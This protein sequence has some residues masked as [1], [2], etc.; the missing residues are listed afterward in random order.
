VNRSRRAVLAACSAGLTALTGCSALDLEEESPKYDPTRVREIGEKR[1][2]RAP[3]S[4]PLSV[5]DEMVARHRERAQTLID[6]VPNDP[7]VPNGAIARRLS[8]ERGDVV[9]SLAEDE[10]GNDGD[11][12]ERNLPP[13]A[14]DPFERLEH[15]RFT[16]AEAANVDAAYR[17]ATNGITAEPVADRRGRLRS[18]LFAFERDRAYRGDDPAVAVAVHR[19]LERLRNVARRGITPERAFPDDPKT[20]VFQV[21]EI[22]G[23]IEK[24]RGALTDAK[25]LRARY[26]DGLSDPHPLRA[27]ISVGTRRL[28]V[29]GENRYRDIHEYVDPDDERLPFDRAIG[30]TPLERSYREMTEGVRRH[31]EE[32]RETERADD[33]ASA[34]FETAGAVVATRALDALVTDIRNDRIDPP[35]TADDIAAARQ[36]AVDALETAWS[37]TPTVVADELAQQAHE[38]LRRGTA[39]LGRYD[40]SDD[41]KPDDRDANRAFA[42]FVRA[43][44]YAEAVPPTVADVRE[45]L[46]AVAGS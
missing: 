20:D 30:G 9:E 10:P 33:P 34:L 41:E 16:R 27:V 18:D 19:K 17:A 46:Q 2:P 15:A 36:E 42:N 11:R 4:F 40:S 21:G 28:R 1:V 35:A 38:L 26:R 29:L 44:R 7:D 32:L 39:Y 31:R 6:R 8:E 24:G 23:R 25:E 3:A 45:T 37:A 43:A 13:P 22:V 5:S 12:E 14:E